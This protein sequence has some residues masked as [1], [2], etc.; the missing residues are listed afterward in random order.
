MPER[1]RRTLYDS[2]YTSKEVKLPSMLAYVMV[3]SEMTLASEPS[4]TD[5][6]LVETTNVELSILEKL[7]DPAHNT[8]Q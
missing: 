3:S 5:P 2:A 6:A 1:I 8:R 4:A 7:Q